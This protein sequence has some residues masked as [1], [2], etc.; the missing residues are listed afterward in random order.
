MISSSSKLIVTDNSGPRIVRCI[1]VLATNRRHGNIGDLIVVSVI[2]NKPKAESKF[3][4]GQVLRAIIVRSKKGLRRPNG[5]FIR[6]HDN[7]VILLNQQHGLIASR[8]SG[9]IP[10]E[11]RAHHQLKILSLA[12]KLI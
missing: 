10:R 9:T 7:A 6:F 3:K 11:L 8:I 12:R 5:N 1:K 2:K 4:K